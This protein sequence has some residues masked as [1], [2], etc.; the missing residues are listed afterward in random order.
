ME[1]RPVLK[2]IRKGEEKINPEKI[3]EKESGKI[4]VIRIRGTVTLHGDFTKTMDMLGL[5]K[6]NF[7]VVLPKTPVY[8]GMVAK[9]KDHVTWGEIDEQ[10]RKELQEKR[11]QKNKKFFR[12]NSPRG[13]LGRRGVKG[14]FKQAGALGYRG[15]KINDSIKRML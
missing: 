5:F 13:G 8:L 2:R 14:T 6:R 3:E 1:A 11:G 7:C 9:V 12:L 10:T 15:E 4:A